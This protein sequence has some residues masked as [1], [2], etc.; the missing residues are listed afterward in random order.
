MIIANFVAYILTI[1]GALNWGLVGIFNFNL[2]A[3]ICGAYRNGWAIAIY[4]LIMLAAIW[5][6]IS[7]IISRGML[8]LGCKSTQEDK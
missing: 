8:D 7:P 3:W 6:I 2:V 5:L 4:V 1:V